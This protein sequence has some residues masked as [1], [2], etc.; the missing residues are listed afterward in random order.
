MVAPGPAPEK[1]TTEVPAGIPVP[2]MDIPGTIPVVLVTAVRV[3]LV[4]VVVAVTA[5]PPPPITE[6]LPLVTDVVAAADKV[7]L[8][9]TTKEATVVP[10]GIPEPNIG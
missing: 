7:I 3:A 5:A 9:F 4:V 6:N 10:T 1:E 8:V 2:V